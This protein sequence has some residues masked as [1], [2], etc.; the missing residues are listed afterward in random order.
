MMDCSLPIS[1]SSTDTFK[2]PFTS[3]RKLHILSKVYLYINI[4]HLTKQRTVPC[5]IFLDSTTLYEVPAGTLISNDT[6][7]VDYENGVIT[8]S[9]IYDGKEATIAALSS[10]GSIFFPLSRI[11][12]DVNPGSGTVIKTLDQLLDDIEKKAINKVNEFIDKVDDFLDNIVHLG[13]YD[14][15]YTYQINNACSFLGNSFVAIKTTKNNPPLINRVINNNYW[16]LVAK[17]GDSGSNFVIRGVY[18]SE[19]TYNVNDVVIYLGNVYYCI[20][21]VVGELPTNTNGNV[22]NFVYHNLCNPSLAS[23][24]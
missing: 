16:K 10:K 23:K 9:S 14:P 8:V 17:K 6:F 7:T 21:S 19:E 2:I 3:I 15:N 20:Q 24:F 1:K 5:F 12:D 13:E 22:S 11:Y 18:N 4:H